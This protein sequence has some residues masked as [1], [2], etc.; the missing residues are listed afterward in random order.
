MELVAADVVV[1]RVHRAVAHGHVRID[2]PVQGKFIEIHFYYGA[3]IDSM[4]GFC[5]IQSHDPWMTSV[6]WA[7]DF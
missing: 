6:R 4:V 3:T 5:V 7:W 1:V 2:A